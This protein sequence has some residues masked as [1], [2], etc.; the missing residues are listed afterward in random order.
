MKQSNMY[1]LFLAVTLLMYCG[2]CKTRAKEATN[3]KVEDA[4]TIIEK[5]KGEF[6]PA[7][8]SQ[9]KSSHLGVKVTFTQDS[10][11]L[12]NNPVSIRPGRL[13]Y[14][15]DGGGDFKVSY[16]DA[17][18]KVLGT[19]YIQNPTTIRSCEEGQKPTI[20]KIENGSFDLLLPPDRL[21]TFVEFS[22]GSD[23][24]TTLLV[25]ISKLNY[26]NKKNQDGRKD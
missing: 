9:L 21:I 4:N 16:K 17:N 13:P 19:Y 5:Q 3:K 15:S 2:S 24:V 10:F 1:N 18:N 22:S 6:N 25:P 11:K 20:K 7:F 23:K 14:S 26:E 12:A 8:Q